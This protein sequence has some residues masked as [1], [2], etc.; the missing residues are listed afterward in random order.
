MPVICLFGVPP[1][2]NR[3]DRR[4]RV[5]RPRGPTVHFISAALPITKYVNGSANVGSRSNV[6]SK[7]AEMDQEGSTCSTKAGGCAEPLFGGIFER[8]VSYVPEFW[9]ARFAYVEGNEVWACYLD[10]DISYPWT[11]TAVWVLDEKQTE[12][13]VTVTPRSVVTS[14]FCC[15]PSTFASCNLGI[16]LNR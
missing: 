1:M 15:S 12:G 13:S 10:G 7:T 5:G 9:Q 2:R 8:L 6:G 16:S 3:P 11:F 14:Y 4:R